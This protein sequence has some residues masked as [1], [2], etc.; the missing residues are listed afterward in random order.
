MAEI[1]FFKDLNISFEE[2][3]DALIQF[4]KNCLGIT[5]GFYKANP[6]ITSLNSLSLKKNTGFRYLPPK[7]R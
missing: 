3:V 6:M 1:I 2:K 4:L 7:W 5:T